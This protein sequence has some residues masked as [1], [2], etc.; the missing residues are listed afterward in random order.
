MFNWI[1][2]LTVTTNC[3]WWICLSSREASK[4]ENLLGQ[5]APGLTARLKTCKHAEINSGEFD[6]LS[7][8]ILTYSLL[9]SVC[10]CPKG[11]FCATKTINRESTNQELWVFNKT[12]CNVSRF[13]RIKSVVYWSKQPT[14]IN[15]KPTLVTR[16]DRDAKPAGWGVNGACVFWIKRHYCLFQ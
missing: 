14:Y 9:L 7:D 2:N 16:S 3:L 15:N 13:Y 10:N 1:T 12:C 11:T 5:C 8:K 4:A 6:R